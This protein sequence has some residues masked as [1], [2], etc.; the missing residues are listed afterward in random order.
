MKS[1]VFWKKNTEKEEEALLAWRGGGY[2]LTQW[3]YQDTPGQLWRP[4]LE[5]PQE[6][7]NILNISNKPCLPTSPTGEWGARQITPISWFSPSNPSH[8]H[9]Q[10]EPELH[11]WTL[12][13]SKGRRQR[14]TGDWECS[15]GNLPL[16]IQ[17][18][19]R[20]DLQRVEMM[21]YVVFVL[22]CVSASVAQDSCSSYLQ[23]V[24]HLSAK[25]NWRMLVI[26]YTS[27]LLILG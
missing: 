17:R 26:L 15:P 16:I 9:Q 6:N 8:P 12:L 22:L 3:T 21:A 19:Y 4:N 1:L 25:P 14:M 7:W 18:Q 2:N 13:S 24:Q 27:V 11:I 5:Q 10:V 20:L 23:T